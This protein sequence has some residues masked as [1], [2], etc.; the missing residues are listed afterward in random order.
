M[1][2]RDDSNYVLRR[3][4]EKA[5]TDRGV[6]VFVFVHGWRHDADFNDS[7]VQQFREFLSRAS[8]N[9]IVGKREVMGLYL[10]WRGDFTRIPVARGLSYWARKDVAEEV[11]DGGVTEILSKL[12]QLLVQQFDDTNVNQADPLYKN[13]FVVIGHSFGGGIVLSALHDILL[14]D[15]VNA[16]LSVGDG[17][18]ACKKIKRFADAVMLLNP[19]IESNRVIQLKEVAAR[20]LFG[21]DQ[22]KLMHVLSSEGDRANQIFFPLGQFADVTKTLSPKKLL[23]KI[24]NKEIVLSESDLNVLTPGHL[25]QIRTA[26]LSFDEASQSWELVKCRDDLAGCGI[27]S[28]KAQANHITTNKND[29]LAFIKTDKHF[30]KDHND[31]FGCYVQSYISAVIFETQS[32]DKGYVNTTPGNGKANSIEG[33]DYSNFDFKTC[34]NNQLID[35]ECENPS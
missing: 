35:Y 23:R 25:K 3:I 6:A 15:L 22:P 12:Q 13:T 31:V 11:G 17:P 1:Y 9:E 14:K 20:C 7:N 2:N 16:D 24:N 29:P 4:N 8:E 5:N 28:S 32:V 21:K 10:G 27:K 19:A 34:F 18:N 26:F 30:I 33:C